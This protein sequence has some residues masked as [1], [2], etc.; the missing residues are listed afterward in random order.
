[1]LEGQHKW[2]AWKWGPWK[3]F[4]LWTKSSMYSHCVYKDIATTTA[5]WTIRSYLQI[6]STTWAQKSHL[7]GATWFPRNLGFPTCSK[8]STIAACCTLMV[9]LLLLS[10]VWIYFLIRSLY[11]SMVSFKVGKS[12]LCLCLSKGDLERVRWRSCVTFQECCRSQ[13]AQKTLV[14]ERTD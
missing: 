5:M 7:W 13:H 8:F 10:I 12:S 6:L 4:I 2:Q 3:S 14:S 1:M 11:S 9:K